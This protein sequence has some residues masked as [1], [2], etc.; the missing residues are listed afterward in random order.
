M[1]T[2]T[3]RASRMGY[4]GKAAPI[5]KPP[6]APNASAQTMYGNNGGLDVPLASY[7]DRREAWLQDD[8]EGLK[9]ARTEREQLEAFARSRGMS[10]EHLHEA[11]TVVG[12]YDTWPKKPETVVTRR[13]ATVEALRLE[14]G[15]HEQAQAHL[16]R[17]VSVTTAIAKEIPT[18]AARASATG[19]VEDPRII[20]ALAHYGETPT[21]ETK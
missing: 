20:N 19:A 7:Y 3:E 12:E 14:K 6:A 18:L 8:E 21:G 10:P 17:Y 15:G 2:H 16:R 4:G 1:S 9:T 5:A 13:A 11:L